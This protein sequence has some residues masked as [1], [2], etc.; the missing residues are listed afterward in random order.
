[1]NIS[2]HRHWTL[3]WLHILLLAE[4]FLRLLAQKFDILLGDGLV[5]LQLLDPLFYLFDF[6]EVK[7]VS[8]AHSYFYL[9]ELDFQKF[10]FIFV[11]ENLVLC[12]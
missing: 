3:H 5:L 12:K 8:A 9:G 7:L 4:Y 2:A 1:M 10:Y 11:S 6:F